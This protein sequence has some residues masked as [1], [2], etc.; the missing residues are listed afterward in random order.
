MAHLLPHAPRQPVFHAPLVVV[1][2]IGFLIAAH[3]GRSLLPPDQSVALLSQYA[4]VPARLGPAFLSQSNLLG[5]MLPFATYMAL[6]N[7]YT[8]LLIN[9]LWLLAFGPIVARRFGP[10]L[11]LVFFLVCGVAAAL[12]HL[13]FNWGS[14]EPVIGASGAISGLMAAGMRLLPTERPV[15][16]GEA[17][18]DDAPMLPLFSRQILF[19]TLTWVGL[20]LVV[21]VAPGVMLGIGGGLVAWQAHIGGYVAGLLLSGL[22][23]AFRPRPVGHPL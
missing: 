18:P 3:I 20:N 2:L 6:H 15:Q 22:F 19:F 9:S 23:D 21:A 7:D 8:H 17:A 12:T 16:A 4:L 10:F 1:L 14:P 11:F 13:L 5:A